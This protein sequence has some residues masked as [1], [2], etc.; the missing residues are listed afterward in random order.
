M[1]TNSFAGG[2]PLALIVTSS[3]AAEALTD[4]VQMV[5]ALL[6]ETAFGGRGPKGPLMFMVGGDDKNERL[7]L[8]SVFPAARLL[9]CQFQMIVSLRGCI[10]KRRFNVIPSHKTVLLHM[11]KSLVYEPDVAIFE[12]KVG[13]VLNHSITLLYPGLRYYLKELLEDQ[14]SW[15]MCH[16]ADCI[17]RGQNTNSLSTA[18]IRVSTY[19]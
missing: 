6:S 18:A 7:A 12:Q 15:A 16:R 3:G 8:H 1:R 13:E 4:G 10:G 5:R 19:H 11:F 17:T 9:F 14:K 2:L